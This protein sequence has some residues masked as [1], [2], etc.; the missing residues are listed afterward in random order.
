[1]SFIAAALWFATAVVGTYMLSRT[2]SG[3]RNATGA[4]VTDLPVMI[5]FLHPALALGGLAVFGGYVLTGEASFVWIAFAD[6]L[7]VSV[8]GEVLFAKWL[9]GR[10]PSSSPV[11]RFPAEQTIPVE[12]VGLHGLLAVATLVVVFV[13]ALQA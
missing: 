8:L 12:I 4:T 10:R 6:L 5:S 9:K 11:R 7:L 1:L 13:I 2:I 3:S